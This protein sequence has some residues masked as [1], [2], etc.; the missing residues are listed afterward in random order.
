M[1]NKIS[2]IGGN[3]RSRKISFEDGEG[4]RPTPVRVRETLFNWLQY[5]VLGSH[6]LDLYAGSGA[7]SFEAASRGAKS[8]VQVEN[9]PVAC[10][11]LKANALALGAEQIICVQSD[12]FRYL[13]GDAQAF[14]LVFIDP[15]F[16]L[17]LAAQ[18]C[19][20]LEDKGWLA[21]YTKIYVETESKDAVKQRPFQLENLPE[22]WRLLKQKTAGEVMYHLFERTA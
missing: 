19:Q 12:V 4:L 10:R 20:C 14:N 18:T 3:W 7:L 21:P 17:N 15:P 1:Q 9:N 11:N 22:N 5:D 8:V 13:A 2:I 16:N 6:C